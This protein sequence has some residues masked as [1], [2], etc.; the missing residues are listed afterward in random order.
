MRCHLLTALAT[1]AATAVA[2]IKFTSP[3]AGAQLA[4]GTAITIT[5]TDDGTAPTIDQFATYQ[6]NVLAG[7]STAASAS[8]IYTVTAAGT[9]SGTSGTVTA[10]IP[11]VNGATSKNGYFLQ[12]ISNGK[13]GGTDIVYSSR[14]GLTGM[15]GTFTAAQLAGIA[16]VGSDTTLVPAA[17]HNLQTA[18]AAGATSAAAGAAM[19]DVAYH[20]Q[21]GLI[22]YAPMQ[23]I[24][25]TKITAKTPSMMN[26]STSFTIFKTYAPPASITYTLTE[27]QTLSHTSRE[28]P[29]SAATQPTAADMKKYLNRWKD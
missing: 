10:I 3:V 4:G 28:N 11:I 27:S 2:E 16:A 7:G 23:P 6:L 5:W 15:T 25:G 12:M 29:A 8:S 17:A 14:F 1:L 26:P 9:Y 21:T 18:A 20:L 13:I 22:K 19:F 24:P